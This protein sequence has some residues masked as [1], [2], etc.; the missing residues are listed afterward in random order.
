LGLQ[1]AARK[2]REPRVHPGAWAGSVVHV[3]VD[4]G[5]KITNTLEE[6]FT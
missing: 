4:D 5:W 6:K 2:R 3:E 1:D